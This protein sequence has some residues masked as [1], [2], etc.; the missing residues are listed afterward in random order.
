M[1]VST[2][3]WDIIIVIQTHSLSLRML[4]AYIKIYDSKVLS[5]LSI[6]SLRD[7]NV[8]KGISTLNKKRQYSKEIIREIFSQ[9]IK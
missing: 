7:M 4:Y 5:G 8:Q 3:T 1:Q 9:S 6:S 2:Q